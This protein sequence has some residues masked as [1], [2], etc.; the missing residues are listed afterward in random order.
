RTA[1][2]RN[3]TSAKSE[4]SL[5]IYRRVGRGLNPRHALLRLLHS[6]RA[7]LRT[8]GSKSSKGM[9]SLHQINWE[10]SR[11]V[12]VILSILF[13]SHQQ[14][15]RHGSQTSSPTNIGPKP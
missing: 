1:V 11:R 14:E 6:T 12:T 5:Y 4:T 13:K 7:K 15:A 2:Y 8:R 9:I 3:R 10:L